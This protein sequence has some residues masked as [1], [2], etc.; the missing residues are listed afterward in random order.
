MSDNKINSKYRHPRY[1]VVGLFQFQDSYKGMLM[2]FNVEII[3][4][5]ISNFQFKFSKTLIW[6][7]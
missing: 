4:F 2:K 1:Y 6:G 5:F 7:C 3:F